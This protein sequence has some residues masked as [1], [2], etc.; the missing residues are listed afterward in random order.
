MFETLRSLF[1][2]LFQGAIAGLIVVLV[3]RYLE[4]RKAKELAQK[5]AMLVTLE[6]SEHLASL[7]T[8]TKTG[9]ISKSAPPMR[10]SNETWTA[11]IEYLT[12][13]PMEDL[14]RLAA[15]YR[16]IMTLNIFLDQSPGPMQ[17]LTKRD[18]DMS[19]LMCRSMIA[20]LSR[21][22][23]RK[24]AKTHDST[25]RKLFAQAAAYQQHQQRS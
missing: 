1:E 6:I 10:F 13:I 22:W 25:Y 15:Y 18:F 20:L 14:L 16:C 24:N 3:T 17:P 5:Y 21:S 19:L 2:L 9:E 8:V 11:S 12:A 4:N 7:E 23:D